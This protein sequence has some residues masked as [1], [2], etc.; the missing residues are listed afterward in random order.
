MIRLYFSA[1]FAVSLIAMQIVFTAQAEA[2]QE[3]L[4]IM[5]DADFSIAVDAG[6]S[7][8]LGVNTALAEAGHMLAGV[9]V[10]VR[11]MDHR[12]N[13][14]R[15]SKNHERFARSETA[16]V[17]I[18]GMH[19]P[20]Y[21]TNHQFINENDVLT[22]LPWSAAGPITRKSARGENWFFRLSVDDSKAGGFFIRKAVDEGGCRSVGLILVETGWGRANEKTLK[23]ALNAR[24]MV[25]SLVE[26]FDVSLGQ[27]SARTLAERA[28]RSGVDC[29]VMLA[30]WD[31]GAMVANA[32]A[33]LPDGVRLFSHWGIMGGPF[34][35]QVA[36]AKREKLEFKV[37][38]TCGLARERQ[39]SA[40]L[41]AALAQAGVS[42]PHLSAVPAP[43]GFVHG[44]DLTRILIAA[45]NQAAQTEAWN[46]NIRSK[47]MAVRAALEDLNTPVPGILADYAHPFAPFSEDTPDAREALGESDLCL[48]RFDDNGVLVPTE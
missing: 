42:P 5:I 9:R 6:E 3:P 7:I 29:A 38:Q 16:L 30:E 46:G 44:Y 22:L 1:L 8:E 33:E 37:L 24:G 11:R 36:A 28:R 21:L 4:E 19:S 15:A 10:T 41:Q 20:P 45:V 31:N 18:G 34:A 25:P 39:G 26:F 14:K 47:R 23:A 27:A 40:A 17:M 12:A 32:L 13:V 35:E 48:A 43:T 2:A